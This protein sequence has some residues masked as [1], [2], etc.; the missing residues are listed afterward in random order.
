MRAKGHLTNFASGRRASF[1]ETDSPTRR[2]ALLFT[3]RVCAWAARGLLTVAA[4]VTFG[5][6]ASGQPSVYGMPG[7]ATQR[8]VVNLAALPQQ[9]PEIN[10]TPPPRTRP[11]RK[12]LD[13]PSLASS[14]QGFLSDGAVPPDTHGAVGLSHIVTSVN[15]RFRVQDRAGR[16]LRTVSYADFWNPVATVVDFGSDQRVLYEPHD[17]RWIIVG[18]TD[19]SLPRPSVLLGVSQTEDPMGQWNL[20]RIEVADVDSADQLW[21]DY[22]QVAFNKDWIVIQV[23]ILRLPDPRFGLSEIYVFNKTNLYAGGTGLFTR[24]E[25]PHDR[26]NKVVAF[27]VASFDRSLPSMY[28]LAQ[29]AGPLGPGAQGTTNITTVAQ[30]YMITGPVG[31]EVLTESSI[32]TATNQWDFTP[33]GGFTGN[34]GNFNFAPQLGSSN[35]IAVLYAAIMGAAFRNGFIWAVQNVFLPAGGSPS[36]TAVQWWQ[37]S[38]EGTILQ[39]G[40][41]DDPTGVKSYAWPSLAVNQ[42]NDVLIG[43]S[44]FSTNQY[45]SANYSFRFGADLPNTT[46]SDTLLKAGEASY[47]NL[48]NGRNRWGDYSATVVDPLNDTDLWTIQEYAAWP[49]NTWGTWWGRVAPPPRPL[50]LVIIEKQGT[51]LQVSFATIAGW[52]YTVERTEDLNGTAGW[53]PVSGAEAVVGTGGVVNVL[54]RFAVGEPQHFCR[55]RLLR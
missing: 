42:F 16:I 28:L 23:A 43:Y 45:A 10:V 55:L 21:P 7:V 20:Y 19:K 13:S 35:K 37:L 49:A 22:P 31:S 51:D 17:G 33:P 14:F 24:F 2:V 30:I 46:R 53:T 27:P 39:H 9:E 32:V 29:E 5:Q 26:V 8:S 11:G 50:P 25:Q 38:P 12:D 48:L 4:L 36:R 47:F 34:W 54:D 44:R 18:K 52:N 6:S 40:L 1:E 15:F 3:R 41:I